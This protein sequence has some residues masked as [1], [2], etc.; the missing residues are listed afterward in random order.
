MRTFDGRSKRLPQEQALEVLDG[1][2]DVAGPSL[3]ELLA[4]RDP[5]PF[6][7]LATEAR[8]VH[9]AADWSRTVVALGEAAAT[10]AC[11]D[12]AHAG[13]LPPRFSGGGAAVLE[14]RPGRIRIE[15][16]AEGPEPALLAVNQTWD[17]GWRAT[18]DGRLVPLLLTDL[19]LSGL[20]VPPGRHEVVLRYE[21]PAVKAGLAL[22][23]AGLVACSALALRGR[24]RL[25]TGAV[26]SKG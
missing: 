8:L 7:F 23:A 21:D 10:T 13:P 16:T 12:A 26:S 18:V 1:L 22:G 20:V 9:D 3:L 2:D 15:V 14:R 17:P 6:A 5:L 11:I 4:L 24:R 19:S 25:R